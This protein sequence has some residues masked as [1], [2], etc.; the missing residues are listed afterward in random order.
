MFKK[1]DAWISEHHGDIGLPI[2]LVIL[3]GTPISLMRVVPNEGFRVS[4]F[5]LVCVMIAVSYVLIIRS[6][7]MASRNGHFLGTRIKPKE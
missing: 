3:M 4:M 7:W 6:A 1:F 2:W 5:Y